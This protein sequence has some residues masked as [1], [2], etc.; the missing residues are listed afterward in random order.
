MKPSMPARQWVQVRAG[1]R[2]DLAG[3]MGD[4]YSVGFGL[5]PFNVVNLDIAAFTGDGNTMGASAQLGLRF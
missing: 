3:N 1:V 4:T 5:S 2:T